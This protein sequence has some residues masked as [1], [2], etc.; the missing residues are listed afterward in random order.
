MGR[1][2]YT[3]GNRFMV[4]VSRLISTWWCG[5]P[6]KAPFADLPFRPR[7]TSIVPVEGHWQGKGDILH[8][9][10]V[11]VPFPF[12]V[13]C[14]DDEGGKLDSILEAPNWVVWAW[15]QQAKTQAQVAGLRPLLVFSRRHRG[16]YVMLDRPTATKIDLKPDRLPVLWVRGPFDVAI[17]DW[18]DLARVRPDALA[19][20]LERKRGPRSA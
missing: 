17:C 15:W 16:V 14:K 1:G 10:D 7:S 13:E 5:T 18:R 20:Q 8:R 2:S 11:P 12:A 3:K 6:P 19:A 4:V 9:P